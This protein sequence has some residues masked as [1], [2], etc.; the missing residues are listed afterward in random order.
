M[1]DRRG[2]RDLQRAFFADVTETNRRD[3]TPSTAVRSTPGFSEKDRMGVYQNAYRLRIRDALADDFSFTRDFLGLDT[4]DKL[5]YA[6]IEQNPSQF[7]TLTQYGSVFP[8]FVEQQK[9]VAVHESVLDLV[10]LE[11]R[12]C[13]SFYATSA[14]RSA[15]KAFAALSEVPPEQIRLCMDPSLYVLRSRWPLHA[16]VDTKTIPEPSDS[17]FLVYRDDVLDACFKS[18][19]SVQAR[20][21]ELFCDGATLA[22]VVESLTEIDPDLDFAAL[23]Q[24][25][26]QQG[27]ILGPSLE[28]TSGGG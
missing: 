1:T 12:M 27:W 8:K 22:E 25:S 19:T 18:V 10:R 15:S 26:V 13:E 3:Q 5:A 23:F 4:F 28:R 16:M 6:C 17:M 20:L 2:I 21:V 14:V 11:W 9:A 24:D 7:W